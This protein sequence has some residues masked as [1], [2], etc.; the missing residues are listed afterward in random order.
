MTYPPRDGK[1]VTKAIHEYGGKNIYLW[2]PSIKHFEAWAIKLVIKFPNMYSIYLEDDAT[3][4]LTH[5][6]EIIHVMQGIIQIMYCSPMRDLM[7]HSEDEDWEID[8]EPKR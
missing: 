3:K 7:P 6:V 4:K 1:I 5:R 2:F 8:D